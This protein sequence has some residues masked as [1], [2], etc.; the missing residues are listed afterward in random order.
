MTQPADATPWVGHF[1]ARGRV[2]DGSLIA[3]GGV[4]TSRKPM[5]LVRALVA[6]GVREL[7]VVSV[8][9]SVDVDL[10]IAAGC[11]AE[12]HTAGVAIDGVGMAPRYR[13][14]RQS[15]EVR[16]VEWSEGSLYAAFDASARGLPSLA[17]SMSPDSDV[18]ANNDN[19]AVARRR[20]HR[21]ARGARPRAHSRYCA[22]A[23]RR[24]VARSVTCSS[25]ATPVSTS[26]QR[27]RP[28]PSSSRLIAWPSALRRRRAC[29]GSGWTNSSLHRQGPGR[30]PPIRSR[31]SIRRR[32]RAG[33]P[34]RATSPCWPAA[35]DERSGRRRHHAARAR[36]RELRCGRGGCAFSPS[37]RRS[38][39]SP[40]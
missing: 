5:S 29:R 1:D 30:R 24:G 35:P 3:I 31:P 22:A 4:G 13:Q 17:C 36:C 19:L 28:V 15:G 40:A 32:C 11:V 27:A 6:A 14:A 2:P 39:W 7:R 23:R 26:S 16:V 38:R 8:L 12:V 34:P 21:R 33:S 10:L 9:G 20:V 37:P 18:V 25:T